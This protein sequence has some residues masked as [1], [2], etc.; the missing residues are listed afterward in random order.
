METT[1]MKR[2][3]ISRGSFYFDHIFTTRRQAAF[4]ASSAGSGAGPHTY[5]ENIGVGS[6]REPRDMMMPIGSLELVVSGFFV[7]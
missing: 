2:A 7:I 6:S 3:P 5:V 1:A 4:E